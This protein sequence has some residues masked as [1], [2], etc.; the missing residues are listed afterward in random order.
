MEIITEKTAK[1]KVFK[2][3]VTASAMLLAAFL[4]ACGKTAKAPAADTSSTEAPAA[5]TTGSTVQS[6]L[7]DSMENG[8]VVLGGAAAGE[9]HFEGT[10]PQKEISPEQGMAAWLLIPGTGVETQVQT[11]KAD[12]VVY[13]DPSNSTE[14]NDPNTVLHGEADTEDAALHGLLAYGDSSFFGKH[15]YLYLYLPDKTIL[16]YKVFAAYTQPSENI[17]EQHDCYDFSTFSSYIQEILSQRNMSS[18]TDTGM[19]DQI[20]QTWCVLTIQASMSDGSDYIVQA[21]LTGAGSIQ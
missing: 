8:E 15:P 18:V 6:V 14:F 7:P 4:S 21:T 1:R 11:T 3:A 2:A 5:A 9:A 10:V 17:L 13:L 20:L 16:E 19:Q 12:H